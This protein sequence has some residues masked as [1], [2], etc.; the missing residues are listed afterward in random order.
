MLG[1]GGVVKLETRC[2]VNKTLQRKL[3]PLCVLC[4]IGKRTKTSNISKRRKFSKNKQ[5][6][7]TFAD[8]CLQ[9]RVSYIN[10]RRR[11][12]CFAFPDNESTAE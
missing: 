6:N 2:I 3:A 12:P 11:F 7:L 1:V 4:V 5:T 8:V 10:A 9:E